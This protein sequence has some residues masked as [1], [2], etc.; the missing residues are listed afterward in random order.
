ME[1]VID[2][3]I[4]KATQ[5]SL[6]KYVKRPPLNDKLLKKPPFR[7]LHDIITTV[8]KSTGFFKGLFEDVELIS[9]NVKDRESKIIF[10]TKVISVIATTTGKSLSVKPSKIVAGQEPDKT[11]ELLQCLAFALDNKL[12]SDE[13]VKL[14]KERGNPTLPNEKKGKDAPKPIKKGVNTKNISS[15]STEK[16]VKSDKN[17]NKTNLRENTI[18]KKESPPKKTSQTSKIISKR[19][20]QKEKQ[21]IKSETSSVRAESVVVSLDA[22]SNSP[23]HN[24]EISQKN[25]SSVLSNS[26]EENTNDVND[27]ARSLVDEDVT[28]S[29]DKVKVRSLDKSNEIENAENDE[30]NKNESHERLSDKHENDVLSNDLNKNTSLQ[31]NATINNEIIHKEENLSSSPV[32]SV[33]KASESKVVDIPHGKRPD[34]VRRPSSSRP[35]APRF[36]DKHEITLSAVDNLVVGK[37]NIIVE[38]TTNEEEEESSIVIVENTDALTNSQDQDDQ[39]Q[40]SSNEHGHLVQQILNAQKEFSEVNGK[41]NIEWQFG[42]QKARDVVNQEIEQLRF[43]VQ[44]LS[45]VANPLGKLLDHIQEDVEIMRQELQQWTKTFEEASKQLLKQKTANE[46]SLLPLHSKVKHL[47]ADIAEKYDKINDLKMVIHKNTLRIEKLLASG[48]VQ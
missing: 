43:N 7:F 17:T 26:N 15:K 36:R 20:Q 14:Y 10:L 39:L 28:I 23:I 24:L 45:R 42:A 22:D 19:G 1:D 6:G 11:N 4:I 2:A 48:N 31:S 27:E 25:E 21:E 46:E 3:N 44:A 47:E 33:V 35:G 40:M 18:V 30:V 12:S 13:A 29:Q 8:L 5:V 37:V 34:S 38:N 41:T 16:L 32:E 9:D